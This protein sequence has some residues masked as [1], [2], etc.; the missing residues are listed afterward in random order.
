MRLIISHRDLSA[1]AQKRRSPLLERP[2]AEGGRNSAAG[3]GPLLRPRAS[4]RLQH[5]HPVHTEDRPPMLQGG[6]HC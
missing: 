4:C 2:I 1:L 3:R 5:T 6:G